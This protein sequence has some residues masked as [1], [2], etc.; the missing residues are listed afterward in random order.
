MTYGLLTNNALA[1]ADLLAQQ[2]ISAAVWKLHVVAPLQ[3]GELKKVLMPYGAVL[4]AE[5]A[6]RSGGVGEHL[7]A[8]FAQQ[9]EGKKYRLTNLGRDIPNQGTLGELQKAVGLDAEGL[10]AA[11]KEMMK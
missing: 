8:E 2:G 4:I 7:L 5:E 9:G 6:E 10:A 1:A 11:L 3:V